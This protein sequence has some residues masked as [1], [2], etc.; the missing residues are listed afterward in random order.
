[1]PFYLLLLF[2][3]PGF[4]FGPGSEQLPEA[5][6]RHAVKYAGLTKTLVT[7]LKTRTPGNFVI[8]ANEIS[9]ED[10]IGTDIST[11]FD[12][13]SVINNYMSEAGEGASYEMLSDVLKNRIEDRFASDD[14]TLFVNVSSDTTSDGF[15]INFSIFRSKPVSI[16][17]VLNASDTSFSTSFDTTCTIK[18]ESDIDLFID[19]GKV[20]SGFKKDG[21]RIR[22]NKLS[23]ELTSGSENEEQ[24]DESD[25]QDNESSDSS[26]YV[27]KPQKT[28]PFYLEGKKYSAAARCFYVNAISYWYLTPPDATDFVIDEGQCYI[29]SYK[30][31]EKGDFRWDNETLGSFS[32]RFIMIPEEEKWDSLV[33]AEKGNRFSYKIDNLFDDEGLEQISLCCN[34]GVKEGVTARNKRNILH[35]SR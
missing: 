16:P 4:V 5:P 22:I 7:L 12:C 25:F 31:L 2:I 3:I 6:Q 30:Q 19:A 20:N 11:V 29:L 9:M 21:V 15:F 17:I 33:F 32:T 26:R 34:Y 1:M 27:P 35:I 13:D 10:L 14:G 8:G 28:I 18:F 23:F 24:T